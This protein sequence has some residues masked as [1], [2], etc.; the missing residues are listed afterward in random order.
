MTVW[1]EWLHHPEKCGVRNAFFQ[2]HLWL[3]VVVGMYVVLMSVSG[4]VIVYR[5]ELFV[6]GFSVERIVDLHANLLAGSTGRFVNGIGAVCLTLICLTGSVIWWP[7]ATHWRRSLGV[8]WHAHFA[9]INWDLHSALGFWCFVFVLVWGFSGIYLSFPQ[10][11]DVLFLLD[12]ADHFVNEGLFRLT[13][14]HFGRFGWFSEAVWALVGLVPTVL[15]LT[16]MFICCRRV[17]YKKPSN[18]RNRIV[19]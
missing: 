16:G 6:M 12:P 13:Q 7:G 19:S 9:R 5:N 1:Q 10:P 18:P 8:E 3:G 17:I 11:F 2:V 14:L 4:S 15:A